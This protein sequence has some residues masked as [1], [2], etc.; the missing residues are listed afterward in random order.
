[1]VLAKWTLQAKCANDPD[2]QES[3]SRVREGTGRDP[4]FPSKGYGQETAAGNWA[5]EYCSDCPVRLACL[6]EAMKSLDLNNPWVKD[7]LQG[8]WGGMTMR[9]R[10][11]LKKKQ[12]KQLQQISER[13]A[14]LFPAS[15]GNHNVLP[16]DGTD[17]ILS[18]A[19]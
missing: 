1:M 3:L 8:V 11:A 5:R 12:T 13:L 16:E 4:F 2:I 17:Q 19:S 7:Q 9:S 15:A 14:E 18:P 10:K 6:A